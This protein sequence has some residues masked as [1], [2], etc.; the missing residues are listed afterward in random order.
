MNTTSKKILGGFIL[1]TAGFIVL[2]LATMF[3]WNWLMPAIFNLPTISFWQSLGL[4]ILSNLLF[5]GKGTSVLSKGTKLNA[6]K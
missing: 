3:L 2:V 6:E 4:V 1:V 5:P